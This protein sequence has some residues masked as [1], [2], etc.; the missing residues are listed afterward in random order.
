MPTEGDQ[1]EAEPPD[2]G[3]PDAWQGDGGP[4]DATLLAA[5]ARGDA[6]AA[7][8]LVE[9]YQALVY[10]I[11]A[12][13][14]LPPDV[15]D[16][17]FQSVF[18]ALVRSAASLRDAQSLPKW[19]ITTTARECWRQAA[20]RGQGTGRGHADTGDGAA[21]GDLDAAARDELPEAEVVRFEE[22][23]RL[24]AAL[25]RL[26]GRCEALLRALFLDR[27][28]PAYGEIARRLGM[29]IGSIGPIRARCLKKL[30]EFLD[31]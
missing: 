16:D 30:A 5:V 26:G 18:L 7:G 14:R 31:V 8:V 20:Q 12:R 6:R 13:Y 25:A 2:A 22:Q 19:L 9:R 21:T 29:P 24:H 15:R 23:H 4:S 28:Q 10:S 3:T 1:T 27:A 17:V 11:P